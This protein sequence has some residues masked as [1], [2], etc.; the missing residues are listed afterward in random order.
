M[1]ATRP[2]LHRHWLPAALALA[3]A[4][5][6][7]PTAAAQARDVGGTSSSR[8]S[9]D[10]FVLLRGDSDGSMMR[11]S[12]SDLRE[13]RDLRE[14]DEPMLYVR[15]GGKGYV[16]R[17]AGVLRQAEA[18]F[19]PQEELGA[20]QGELGERQGALGAKQGALG[21]KQAELGGRQAAIAV[22]HVASRRSDDDA[23]AQEALSRQQEELGR[24]Q[25]ALGR[26][27]EALGEQQERLGREQERLG[28]EA[29][30]KLN[31]LVDDALR[32]GLAR[33]VD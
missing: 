9:G 17:D 33:A 10:S 28:R 6:V 21:A 11:G 23:R 22:R 26:Q 1:F 7:A 8:S 5:L 3:A 16:I 30:T 12:L 4:L 19:K 2:A 13:A 24:Q 15:R 18:I 25:E 20:R 32:R 31:A 29:E 14:G 27:Q